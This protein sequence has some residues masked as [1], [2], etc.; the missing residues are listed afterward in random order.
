[1]LILTSEKSAHKIWPM[2]THKNDHA[3]NAVDDY[4]FT[5]P[6]RQIEA[7]L[8]LAYEQRTAN[9]IALWSNPETTLTE[10]RSG[11][12]RTQGIGTDNA[13][14]LFKEILERLGL[15]A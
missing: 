13:D 7:T 15:E 12:Q 9:L 10:L 4:H 5:E 8:A 11:R 1:M 14:K 6:Q 2:K 3:T